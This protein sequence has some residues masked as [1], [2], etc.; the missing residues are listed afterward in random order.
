MALGHFGKGFHRGGAA[1]IFEVRY[2]LLEVGLQLF[3][4]WARVL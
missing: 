2:Q 3:V 4:I 1:I